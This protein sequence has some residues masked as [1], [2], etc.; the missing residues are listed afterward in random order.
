[1]NILITGSGEGLGAELAKT[2]RTSGN[3]VFE[4][5]RKAGLDVRRPPE[6][7]PFV[8]LDVL[9]NNA[10]VNR[11]GMLEAFSEAEWD[12]VLDVNAK[13]IY[14]MTKALLPYLIQSRGT[15]LNIVS[16]AA[17]V[18]MTASL[19]YNASKGA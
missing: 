16:N 2:L 13:G 6:R 4:Y 10:G 18:P 5:D 14:M 17:H 12:E 8:N 11:I 19:A 15:V 1:M 7:W 9:I 3:V